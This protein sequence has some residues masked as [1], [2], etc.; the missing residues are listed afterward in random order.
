M[1]IWRRS[2]WSYDMFYPGTIK[3]TN[4]WRQIRFITLAEGSK[5]G[6][7]QDIQTGTT[8]RWKLAWTTVTKSIQKFPMKWLY[9]TRVAKVSLLLSHSSSWVCWFRWKKK[10]KALLI[11]CFCNRGMMH[12]KKNQICMHYKSGCRHYGRPWLGCKSEASDQYHNC[13]CGALDMGT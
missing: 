2:R 5:L 7:L 1:W 3:K 4:I 13:Y 10:K 12:I 9:V 6:V 11:V 8:R